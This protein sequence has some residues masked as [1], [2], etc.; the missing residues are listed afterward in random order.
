[1]RGVEHHHSQRGA[2]SRRV[3]FAISICTYNSAASQTLFYTSCAGICNHSLRPIKS[4]V[5][6]LLWTHHSFTKSEQDIWTI[7]NRFYVQYIW[8]YTSTYICIHIYTYTVHIHTT[9][10]YSCIYKYIF[11]FILQVVKQLLFFTEGIQELQVFSKWR[12]AQNRKDDRICTLRQQ[13][14][15]ENAL[16]DSCCTKYAPWICC[17]R[18]TD[19][20]YI[21]HVCLRA[22][23]S[24][25]NAAASWHTLLWHH[26][27]GAELEYVSSMLRIFSQ[28]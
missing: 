27:D 5:R 8:I 22:D 4:R 1:M 24:G 6:Q 18:P 15:S 19:S 17:L 3:A 2:R 13:R 7:T 16:A 11:C 23:Y 26:R 9:Y 21:W 25:S 20:R 12:L 10:A 14:G 28:R